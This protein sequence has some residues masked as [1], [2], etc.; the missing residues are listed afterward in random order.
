MIFVFLLCVTLLILSFVCSKRDILSPAVITSAVW[1]ICLAAFW[2]LHHN[3]PPL[4]SQFLGSLSL[5]VTLLCFSSL[6]MQSMRFR[7]SS[8]Q[9]EPSQFVRNIF[10][11]VSVFTYP[12]LIIFA[13]NALANGEPGD[14]W[15]MALRKAAIGSGKGSNGVYGG[16]HILLWQVAYI[17]ELLYFSKKNWWKVLILA[18]FYLSV[19]VFTMSRV[20]FLD[21]FIKTVCILYFRKKI[22][23]QHILIG[24]GLLLV[25]FVVIQQLRYNVEMDS[26]DKVDFV[27][28]YFVANMT[29]FDTLEPA[30]SAHWG[31][32]VF[33]FFYSVS[34]K[35]GLSD[36]EPVNAIL[37]FIKKPVGTNTYTVMYP[38]FKDFGYWGVGIFAVLLGAFYGWVF[39]KAQQGN[40]L[41]ILLYT[42]IIST[43]IM[44]YVA[45]QFLTNLTTYIKQAL[46]IVLP[47]IASKFDLF[48]VKNKTSE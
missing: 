36:I 29:A 8:Y 46:L 24:V 41:F 11:W 23:M 26:E 38:F 42:A 19:G 27:V 48:T 13:I 22:K 31:E 35:L 44:Q 28:L 4:S 21:F 47:F 6:L 9:K 32:N 20:V 16:L 3:L 17:I 37:A 45:E 34:Y 5:W 10:F 30:S 15:S 14:G 43:I 2:V 25:V 7:Q 39:K 18:F 40:K 33:R 1:V 12:L